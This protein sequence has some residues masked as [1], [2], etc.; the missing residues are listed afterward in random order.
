MDAIAELVR[1]FY[2][3]YPFPGYDPRKYSSR[4]DL[5]RQASWYAR[6][7]DRLIPASSRILDAGCG[8]GQFALLL[9]LKD[10]RV[11]GVDFSQASLDKAEHLRRRLRIENTR[12]QQADLLDL[13]LPPASFDYVFCNGVLHHTPDPERGFRNIARTLAPHGKLVVGLYNL[14]GRLPLKVRQRLAALPFVRN[15]ERVRTR[16]ILR[17]IV[18]ESEDRDKVETWY[19]DQYLH[20]HESVH[21]VGQTLRWFRSYGIRYLSS[22]PC[23]DLFARHHPGDDLFAPPLRSRLRRCAPALLLRQLGW[24]FSLDDAGGYYVLVG[25]KAP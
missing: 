6:S 3:R 25:E 20:P 24:I 1:D 4:A 7:L 21:T 12:F 19:A 18:Y 23:L 17:Q 2:N 10:R 11:L 14:F 22:V 9:G 15:N 5:E 16:L 8:T 13:D